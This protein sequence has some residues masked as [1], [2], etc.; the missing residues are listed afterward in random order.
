MSGRNAPR[1][2]NGCST[3]RRR[4]VKCGEERPVCSRC[5]NLNLYCEWGIPVKRARGTQAR[6]L[7]PA[8]AN[9]DLDQNNR[10]ISHAGDEL[11]CN[12]DVRLRDG[13]PLSW[14]GDLPYAKSP[15]LSSLFGSSGGPFLF[16]PSLNTPLTMREMTC[17]NSLTLTETDRKYFDYFPSSS[18]VYYYMKG[19]RWSSFCYLYSGPAATNK[20]IMRMLLAM[21]ASDMHRHGLVGR[22]PGRPTADDHGR[23]HYSLAVKEFRQ[24]LETP[25]ESVSI[26]ELEVIFATMFLMVTYEWQFGHSIRHLQLHLH[27]IRSLLG[28]HPQLFQL[29]NVDEMLMLSEEKD[30]PSQSPSKISFISEQLLLWTLYVDASCGP[31]GIT[32]S[33]NDFVIQSQNPALHPDHLYRCARLWG[34]C[35][36]GEQYPDQ[37]VLDDN[38]NYRAL[39][40]IHNGFCFRHRTWKVLVD[41]GTGLETVDS[42]ARDM[43]SVRER[44]S[45]LFITAKISRGISARRTLHTIH[46]GVCTFY[47]QVIFHRRLLCPSSLPGLVHKQ[48]LAGIL[49]ITRKQYTSDA[50]LLRRMQWPLLMAVIETTDPG[51]REWL[52]Q[53]LVELNNGHSE[54]VWTNDVADQI[55][56][57]QEARP[58]YYANLAELL[59][60]RLESQ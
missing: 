49:D 26:A 57:Q 19:W 10:L 50:R 3:C 9:N 42:L 5:L 55:L 38:E 20:V 17:A 16:R 33:L 41:A 46:M 54:Y 48:A 43:L 32:E 35:F 24:L 15:Q 4:K 59:R 44:Y 58:G 51:Q 45:D 29:K 23:Y 31:M 21:A 30:S 47:A 52:R 11:S 12:T 22:S 8:P 60:S 25:R 40:L 53:R 27:G 14:L 36:W 7:Q 34:R 56:A 39:E 37:E 6:P 13:S 28:S 1:S 18:I 2:K